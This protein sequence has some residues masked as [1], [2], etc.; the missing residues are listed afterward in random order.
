MRPLPPHDT[1]IRPAG[2]PAAIDEA[3]ATLAAGGCVALPTET[4]YGLAADATHGEAVAGIYDAK[5]RP[6][7]NPLIAHCDSRERAAALVRLG[8][9]GTALARAFWPGPLTLV[10]PRRSGAPV[11]DLAAAGLET[12]AVRVPRSPALAALVARLDRPLAAPSA[13]ASGQVS[14]TTAGHVKDSLNGRIHLI[15]DGGACPVGVESAIVDVSVSPPRLLRPGGIARETLEAVCGPLAAPGDA[16]AAPGMLS[17]HYAPRAA[18]RL[19]ATEAERGEA[20]LAFGAH[21]E[22]EAVEIFNLSSV[23]DLAE[24]AANLFS[25][26]RMLDARAERIAVAPIPRTGLGE[27]INDRLMRAAAR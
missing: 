4:V 10:A 8:E 21:P 18:I 5:G 12:L 19:D 16:V 1:P 15:L 23:S 11:S 24:A 27:A 14:P 22:M 6:R 25:G 9:T 7:F 13:N 26:L 3:A 17:S 2:D 20:Y